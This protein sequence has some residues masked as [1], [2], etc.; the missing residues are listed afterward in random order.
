MFGID[1]TIELSVALTLM[2]AAT[3]QLPKIVRQVQIAQ[4]KLLE[5]SKTSTWGHLMIIDTRGNQS[6]SR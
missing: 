2:A 5:E 6:K 4:F 3:G 1:K